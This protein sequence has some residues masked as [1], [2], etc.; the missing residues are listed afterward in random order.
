MNIPLVDLKAQYENIKDEINEAINAVISKTAFVGGPFVSE[1]ET[2]FANFCNVKHCVGVGNGTDAIFI[3]LKC[4][5]IG[6]GDEVITAANSF[7][8]TSEAI[9]MTGANVVFVDINPQTYN[10]DTVKLQ[11]FVEEKCVF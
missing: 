9:T 1:F 6:K 7:I 10:I 11:E 5:G 4:L 2:N 3:A 8:A